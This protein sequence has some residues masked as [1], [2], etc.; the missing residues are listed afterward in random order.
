VERAGERLL[1]DSAGAGCGAARAQ[2]PI[3]VLMENATRQNDV[4]GPWRMLMP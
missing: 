4:I 2:V 1:A 3:R